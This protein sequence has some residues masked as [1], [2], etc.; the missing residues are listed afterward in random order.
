MS[1][2]RIA[3]TTI[4]REMGEQENL[5]IRSRPLT[6]MM[7][8]RGR[9]LYNLSGDTYKWRVRYDEHD[10]YENDLESPIPVTAKNQHQV[11]TLDVSSISLSDSYSELDKLKN[12]GTP[13]IVRFV[14]NMLTNLMDS[15]KNKWHG[16]WFNNVNDSGYEDRLVGIPS[17]F[18]YSGTITITSG[19]NRTA[20]NADVAY[21]P[22]GTYA[23]LQ[24][25]RGYYGGSWS[26]T[27]GK[28]LTF[29]MGKGDAKYDFWTPTITNYTSTAWAGAT[30]TWDANCLVA[31]RFC[32]D[33]VTGRSGRDSGQK[34][35][36]MPMG[37]FS[38]WKNKFDTYIRADVSKPHTN[39]WGFDNVM[40]WDGAMVALDFDCPVDKAYVLSMNRVRYESCYAKKIFNAQGPIVQEQAQKTFFIV[41][42]AGQA[43]FDSPKHFGML[44][45]VA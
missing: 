37:L 44:A 16:E 1:W 43:F 24:V 17:L 4:A 42:T 31:S 8:D 36:L 27:Y 5:T 26:T 18:P 6:K 45:A 38:A 22:S 40:E 25:G 12:R 21:D 41:T 30:N 7:Q 11:A 19:A 32:L 28:N 23:G 14:E 2:D 15:V 35:I 20:N 33:A 9:I 13:A 3:K 34:L 29:P 10:A 39:G